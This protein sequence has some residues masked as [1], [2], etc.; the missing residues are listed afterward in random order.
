M[1]IRTD[2]ITNS[3][4]SCGTVNRGL[5]LYETNG[6]YECEKCGNVIRTTYPGFN[7]DT[8]SVKF[9]DKRRTQSVR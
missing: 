3:S 2:F 7:E 1:K 4:S 6:L 5:Y 9:Q 8:S